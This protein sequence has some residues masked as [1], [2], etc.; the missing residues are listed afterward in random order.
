MPRGKPKPT[1]PPPDQPS[2]TAFL[3]GGAKS[4]QPGD[5]PLLREGS[6]IRKSSDQSKFEA[7]VHR[8]IMEGGTFG[9]FQNQPAALAYLNGQ[10]I[11]RCQQKERMQNLKRKV[12]SFQNSGLTKRFLKVP[13]KPLPQDKYNCEQETSRA[14]KVILE[15]HLFENELVI[16]KKNCLD[17][18]HSVKPKKREEFEYYSEKLADLMP[19]IAALQE[20]RVKLQCTN[21]VI[22][23]SKGLNTK[24]VSVR[25]NKRIMRRR[26]ENKKIAIKD[27]FNRNVQS[28]KTFLSKYT[29]SGFEEKF[30]IVMKNVEASTNQYKSVAAVVAASDSRYEQ[31]NS[32]VEEVG[33]VAA[34]ASSEL[35]ADKELQ[36]SDTEMSEAVDLENNTRKFKHEKK[37]RIIQL[38]DDQKLAAGEF[39]SLN[40]TKKDQKS[41]RLLLDL[42]A[43]DEDIE[44]EIKV[45]LY[46]WGDEAVNLSEE[47]AFYEEPDE[48][49]ENGQGLVPEVSEK[50]R[51]K[52]RCKQLIKS[53]LEENG[54]RMKIKKL[55]RI[56]EEKLDFSET[57][58]PEVDDKAG[59]LFEKYIAKMK[60]VTIN[61]KYATV[62]TL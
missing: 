21:V 10:I 3:T 6:E 46:E 27:A 55:K 14:S 31:A 5:S 17:D 58:E 16:L 39:L 34:G 47:E 40:F 24:G 23:K 1:N 8:S 19:L 11:L 48:N 41:L 7:E 52:R 15:L 4:W 36:A 18:H 26:K 12:Q 45:K 44:H 2:M 59:D 20:I 25:E 22:N 29:E 37:D 43:V 9:F 35:V 30:Q 54:Q 53:I 62:S 61:G 60:D 13:S 32:D 51:L 33:T 56:F 49:G 42:K 57:K 38:K 50:K 28:L